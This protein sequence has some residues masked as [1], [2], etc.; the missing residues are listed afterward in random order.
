MAKPEQ[1][2]SYPPQ[3]QELSWGKDRIRPIVLK[4]GTQALL[5]PY[6]WDSPSKDVVRL[7]YPQFIFLNRFKIDRRRSKD[8]VRE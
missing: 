6:Y 5:H 2:I 3:I 8:G 7:E 4:G 1:E